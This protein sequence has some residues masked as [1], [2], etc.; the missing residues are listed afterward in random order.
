MSYFSIYH[1]NCVEALKQAV[2][3][4]LMGQ[5]PGYLVINELCPEGAPHRRNLDT[6]ESPPKMN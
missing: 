3:L 6:I 4:A 5:R 1:C 2:K